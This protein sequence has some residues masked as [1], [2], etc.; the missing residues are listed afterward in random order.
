V[1]LWRRVALSLSS[2]MIVGLASACNPIVSAPVPAPV[3][4]QAAIKPAA[5]LADVPK[6]DLDAMDAFNST[7]IATELAAFADNA[8]VKTPVGL[9]VGKPQIAEWLKGSTGS[10]LPQPVTSSTAIQ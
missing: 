4:A 1:S 3:P 7:N 9:W 2:W 6:A 5:G 8:V 10:P